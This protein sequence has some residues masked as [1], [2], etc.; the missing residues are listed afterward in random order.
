[1]SSFAFPS[2]ALDSALL[3]S[4]SGALAPCLPCP[5]CPQ[6]MNDPS[7]ELLQREDPRTHPCGL[8]GGGRSGAAA[9]G[10]TGL[11]PTRV[12]EPILRVVLANTA[13]LCCLSRASLRP[14]AVELQPGATHPFLLK[15]ALHGL[16]LVKFL[17]CSGTLPQKHGTRVCDQCQ[18]QGLSSALHRAGLQCQECLGQDRVS[19]RRAPPAVPGRG[20]ACA[21]GAVKMQSTSWGSLGLKHAD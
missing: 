3:E 20:A 6:D 16:V 11:S 7:T 15:P 17:G 10:S 13:P 4:L 9:G 5:G 19:H 18:L 14:L 1:M 2:V 8:G 12:G 21:V